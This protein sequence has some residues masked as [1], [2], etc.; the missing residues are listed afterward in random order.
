MGFDQNNRRAFGI[1]S[2][3]AAEAVPSA[4]SRDEKP[5]PKP[6]IPPQLARLGFRH[7]P[8]R[9]SDENLRDAVLMDVLAWTATQDL[10][11]H[12]RATAF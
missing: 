7:D 8:E 10:S 2:G 11:G 4:T 12:E 3:E 5:P 9:P 1:L 6:P